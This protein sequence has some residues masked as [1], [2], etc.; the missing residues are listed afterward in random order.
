MLHSIPC[1]LIIPFGTPVEPEVNSSLATVPEKTT[2]AADLT[3]DVGVV[4]SSASNGVAGDPGV[5]PTWQAVT[6]ETAWQSRRY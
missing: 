2:P 4:A 3:A 5:H 6:R 1:E